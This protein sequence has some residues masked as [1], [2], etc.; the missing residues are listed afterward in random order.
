MI[1][2]N[3][4]GNRKSFGNGFKASS[5]SHSGYFT[6]LDA[7][8]SR[9]QISHLGNSNLAKACVDNFKVWPLY[10]AYKKVDNTSEECCILGGVI[11]LSFNQ[12]VVACGGKVVKRA[13]KNFRYY[14]NA[15]YSWLGNNASMV[16]FANMSSA[17]S[18]GVAFVIDDK[19]IALIGGETHGNPEVHPNTFDVH[20]EASGFQAINGSSGVLPK[21]IEYPCLVTFQNQEEMYMIANS[22]TP[23]KSF[24]VQINKRTLNIQTLQS[25]PINVER[26]SCTG[27]YLQNISTLAVVVSAIKTKGYFYTQVYTPDTDRWTVLKE[28]L[29]T[30]RY[31]IL[32]SD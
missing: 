17:R 15:C 2:W 3:S 14:E 29:A 26:F 31:L 12:M 30:P 20:R 9:L 19:S 11:V 13:N 23:K 16:H 25:P 18:F 22:T 7:F 8:R 32:R 24:Y 10:P 6:V 5:S 21:E 28:L 1:S 4:N 27:Q